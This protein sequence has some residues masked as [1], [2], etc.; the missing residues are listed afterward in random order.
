VL[1]AIFYLVGWFPKVDAGKLAVLIRK[2]GAVL[3]AFAVAM[4]A[5]RNIGLGMLAAMLTFSF[6]QRTGW[7]PGGGGKRSAAG[8]I[9]TVR[10]A[11]L[12]MSLDHATGAMSGRMLKGRYAGRALSDFTG[13]ERL[14]CLAELRANDRQA[15]QLFEAFLDRTA[16]GWNASASEGGQRRSGPS[17]GMGVEEAYL[18]LG[19]NPGATRDEVQA[20]H[21]NLM[22]RYHPDQGGSNYLASKVNEAKDVLLKQI[23]A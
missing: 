6:M 2:W 8:S 13:A 22:K 15:A 3:A 16:P 1:G 12:E 4:I 17:R 11:Y 14:D 5:T 23:K 18:V 10:T 19:L 7:V 9:S 20:A 21:R